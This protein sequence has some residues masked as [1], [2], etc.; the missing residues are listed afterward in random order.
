MTTAL[1]IL[2]KRMGPPQYT[3]AEQLAKNILSR[4]ESVSA[5][6]KSL[7]EDI[8][9]L[10]VEFDNLKPGETI[11]GCATKKEF[12]EKK[13]H[14][15]PQAVRYMLNPDLRASKQCL[16][17][18]HVRQLKHHAQALRTLDVQEIDFKDAPEIDEACAAVGAIA[19]D[20]RR[21]LRPPVSRPTPSNG[22]LT[23]DIKTQ[24][25]Q[26]AEALLNKLNL[27]LPSCC[28][29]AEHVAVATLETLGA[30]PLAGEVSTD[31]LNSIVFYLKWLQK[32]FALYVERIETANP[33]LAKAS[34]DDNAE[35]QFQNYVHAVTANDRNCGR[36]M[37]R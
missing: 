28:D 7:E 26:D 12:C 4:L 29:G 8:R 11:L 23:T 18:E 21:Q 36:R 1:A 37:K 17:L 25:Q 22:T 32:N 16:P 9:R 34:T 20:V 31:T 6:L 13:L 27:L 15:T 30:A 5:K 10:W 14:R 2:E 19:K 3:P 24:T 35:R 33:D